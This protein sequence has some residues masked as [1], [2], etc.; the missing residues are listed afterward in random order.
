M[1]VRGR[2]S[3][4]G[5][6][7]M[8]PS[9]I[10]MPKES[11]EST[12]EEGAPW[13]R[14]GQDAAAQL[15]A[16][17]PAGASLHPALTARANFLA[18]DSETVC[19]ARSIRYASGLSSWATRGPQ[20]GPALPKLGGGRG[21]KTERLVLRR[22]LWLGALGVRPRPACA[23]PGP[24]R[25]SRG[26][27]KSCSVE[28]SASRGTPTPAMYARLQEKAASLSVGQRRASG[29]ER[30]SLPRRDPRAMWVG[31]Q[32]VPPDL[33]HHRIERVCI[34]GRHIERCGI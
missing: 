31:Q 29:T 28:A 10:A 24:R 9:K 21:S 1:S 22:D 4:A 14:S 18:I 23:G 17:E 27:G 5:A 8:T 13:R 25:P 16:S 7:D 26:M 11:V 15:P 19:A 32:P 12:Q 34:L 30:P 20:R 2:P 6:C 33:P 3:E